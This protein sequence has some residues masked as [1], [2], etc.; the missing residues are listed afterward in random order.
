M[1]YDFGLLIMNVYQGLYG[2]RTDYNGGAWVG[3]ASTLPIIPTQVGGDNEDITI[4]LQETQ[5][6]N[7]NQTISEIVGGLS[8]LGTYTYDLEIIDSLPAAGGSEMDYPT[9]FTQ[10]YIETT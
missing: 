5:L 4:S 6:V 3:S 1:L 9:N 8:L 2:V 7:R 10:F